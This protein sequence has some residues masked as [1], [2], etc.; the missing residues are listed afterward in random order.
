M[1]DRSAKILLDADGTTGILYK[2]E[3]GMDVRDKD[4]ME[5]M[6]SNYVVG[7]TWQRSITDSLD[8]RHR[9]KYMRRRG[10]G[11]RFLGYTDPETERRFSTI[12]PGL[13]LIMASMLVDC[14]YYGTAR[15]S[16][17]VTN[18]ERENRLEVQD[19]KWSGT[20]RNLMKD[21]V[22]NLLEFNGIPMDGIDIDSTMDSIF[23]MRCPV[24]HQGNMEILGE[25]PNEF[26]M[27]LALKI[28]LKV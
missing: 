4:E 1:D 17:L 22:R 2:I 12:H 24:G 19:P 8:L 5:A 11:L 3:G 28:G 13:P 9:L 10:L 27:V 20:Y 6:D 16:D 23:L 25:K 14:Y 26:Q 15:F 18:M 7:L 21:L